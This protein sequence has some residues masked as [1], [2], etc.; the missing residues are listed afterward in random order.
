LQIRSDIFEHPDATREVWLV[1]GD[2]LN[3]EALTKQLRG[4]EARDAVAGQLVHLLSSLHTNCTEIN[5]A[6]KVFCH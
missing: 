2:T 1:V 4:P 5:V 6:L 3:K